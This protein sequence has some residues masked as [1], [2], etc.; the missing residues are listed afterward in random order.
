MLVPEHAQHIGVVV[1][2]QGWP[3]RFAGKVDSIRADAAAAAMVRGGFSMDT[4]ALVV[5]VP[6]RAL[7]K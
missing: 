5:A 3:Q 6:R 2:S 1:S 4:G 7:F